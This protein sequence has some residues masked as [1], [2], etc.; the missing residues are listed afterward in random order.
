[1]TLF[2]NPIFLTQRRLV[3]RGGVLA[4]ILI[5]ALIGLSLLS[6]LIAYL[7]EPID[8]PSFNSPQDAGQVFYGWMI[9]VEITIFVFGGTARVS[10]VLANERKNGLWDSNRL[11]PMK[12]SQLV[13]GYWFGPPL[14]EFYMSLVLA[15]IGLVAVLLAKL[16]ITF[17]LGTQML[18]ISTVLFLELFAILVGLIFN[19]PQGGLVFALLLFPVLFSFSAPRFLFSNFILPIY[20]MAN[21]FISSNPS[22]NNHQMDDWTTRPDIFGLPINPVLLTVGLQLLIGIFLW[23]TVIRKI[24]NPFRLTPLRWEAVALFAIF[25]FF[26]HALIWGLWDGQY[27]EARNQGLANHENVGFLLP[28]VHFGTLALAMVVL[29]FASPPPESI[30]KEV[31]GFG[32]KTQREIFTRSSVLIATVLTAIASLILFTQVMRSIADSWEIYLI[33]VGNLFA[34]PLIFSLLLE[35]CRLRYKRHAFGFV[36]LWLFILCLLPLVLGSVFLN[37]ALAKFSLLSPGC[38]ALVDLNNENLNSFFGTLNCLI[39]IVGAHVLIAVLLFFAWR[40][41]WQKLLARAA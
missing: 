5:A 15:G 20:G 8:F 37:G 24:Q 12:P 22:N 3:H 35:F 36:A 16:P 1:V 38:L 17:W 21:L 27:A 33:A 9:G 30:R 11:T 13:V 26:Q 10:T 7:I 32:L 4:A 40:R 34:F 41:E 39:S 19:R 18:I 25:V 23:R 6:G 14:R 31:L 29:A 28:V 2:Q